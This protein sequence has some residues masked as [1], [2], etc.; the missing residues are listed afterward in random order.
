MNLLVCQCDCYSDAEKLLGSNP[1]DPHCIKC[2]VK[3]IED[4]FKIKTKRAKTLFD[5]ELVEKTTSKKMMKLKACQEVVLLS[6]DEFSK[7]AGYSG[8]GIAGSYHDKT[9]RTL[10]IKG[11]W[12]FAN[13]IHE[14]LHSRSVFSKKMASS[15]LDF[16][17][18]GL[19]ELLVGM[20]LRKKLPNCF[21]KWKTASSCF[22]EPYEKY[23]KPWYYLTYKK[24]FERIVNL[25][26]NIDVKAP[27]DELCRLLFKIHDS[28][29]KNLF[30]NYQTCNY[31]FFSSFLDSM[32][33]AFPTDFA[34]FQG[35]RLF[36][37]TFEHLGYF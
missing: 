27:F 12:C 21:N 15:N 17:S 8:L 34:E 30:N 20:V 29:F 7:I 24:N 2:V 33:S 16:I 22:L 5:C 6:V 25:Y 23:V 28:D 4:T 1:E 26:F 19:T 11:E 31:A 32:G 36:N 9:G 3:C 37:I 35:T 14:T 18:E 13:L 10:L